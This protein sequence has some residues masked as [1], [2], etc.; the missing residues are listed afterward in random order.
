MQITCVDSVLLLSL[1]RRNAYCA[2]GY[3]RLFSLDLQLEP[4]LNISRNVS[5]YVS[6]LDMFSTLLI[7]SCCF[8]LAEGIAQMVIIVVFIGFLAGVSLKY[9]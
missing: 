9:F 1:S 5:S 4:H 2:D 7:Q 3:R 8:G 6:L